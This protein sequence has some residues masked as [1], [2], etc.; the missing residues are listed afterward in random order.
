MREPGQRP[1]V[2]E[3]AR[4]IFWVCVLV[5]GGAFASWSFDKRLGL[6]TRWDD[7]GAP[8]M[9]LTYALAALMLRWRPQWLDAIVITALIPTSVYYLGVLYVAGLDNSTT[10]LYSMA[11]NAQFMPLFYVG[12]FVAL[13]RGAALLSWLHYAGLV[14]LYLYQYG[15][16]WVSNTPANGSVNAHVWATV[17]GSHPCYIIALHFITTLKG[18]LRAT[19][20]ASHQSKERFLAMLS[21]EIRSPL[22]AILGS[23]DLLALKASS[24]PER[25]AVDRI[26]HAAAQLDTH[27]RDVT[28]YT[29]LEN[30]AWRLQTT[31]VDLPALVQDVCDTFMPKAQAAGLTLQM[32][33]PTPDTLDLHHVPTDEARVRQ[34]LGNLIGNAIKYT[35]T[36]HIRVQ[37]GMGPTAASVRIDVIDTGIGIPEADQQRIFE[38]YVRLEDR[39]VAG[40]E[41]SGLGLA[42]VNRLVERLEGEL[43]V[44]SQP[45]QGSCFSVTLPLT[46]P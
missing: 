33:S 39:R 34:I 19:E 16:P 25:R 36:G 23:I 35:P 14:G 26:R 45:D 20:L 28:E 18:R 11:G 7:V 46:R 27:L 38:P 42:V 30:P 24:P 17:L 37:L 15:L 21:H 8:V 3:Q 41:G 9:G 4:L 44:R 40:A 13:R 43:S 31:S 2:P 12:A 10:G 22:Q 32:D 5:T 6:N 29:R 1:G